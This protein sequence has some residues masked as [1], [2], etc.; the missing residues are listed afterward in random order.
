[1]PLVS[2]EDVEVASGLDGGLDAASLVMVD[3]EDERLNVLA[4]GARCVSLSSAVGLLAS[5]SINTT[6]RAAGEPTLSQ[7]PRHD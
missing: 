5:S 4:S 1:M 6:R 3:V 7:L 2:L